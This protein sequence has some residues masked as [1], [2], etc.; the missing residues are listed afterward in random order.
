MQEK[1][2]ILAVQPD[3]DQRETTEATIVIARFV[4]GHHPGQRRVL[5]D[6]AASQ[7]ENYGGSHRQTGAIPGGY[8]GRAALRREQCRGTTIARNILSSLLFT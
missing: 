7:S 1:C 2:D 6:S 5:S 8:S 4:Q 3:W